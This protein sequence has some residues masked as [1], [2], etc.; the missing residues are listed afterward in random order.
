[1]TDAVAL[2]CEMVGAGNRGQVDL[3][4]R[5][6]VVNEH[7]EV[8][9]DRF[10]KPFGELEVTDYRTKFSGIRP[11]DLCKAQR[12]VRRLIEDRVL[13]GHDIT[14]DLKVLQLTHRSDLIKDTSLYA[15]FKEYGKG[16][17]PGLKTLAREILKREIQQGEHCSNLNNQGKGIFM[18]WP[19]GD[20]KLKKLTER[21]DERK[22]KKGADVETIEY[23][24]NG[25]MERDIFR[26][27]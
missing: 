20:K 1:M 3:L 8:L 21:G 17:K 2:D 15:P 22:R 19:G 10:V 12:S 6:S 14:N 5:V 4:G 18:Q 26:G 9:Y 11:W 24:E 25:K 23:T 7:F 16:P 13:V 27:K